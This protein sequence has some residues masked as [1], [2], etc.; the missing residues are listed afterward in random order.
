YPWLL[1]HR[2]GSG[3][4][5]RWN[6]IVTARI[7]GMTAG[8]SAQAQPAATQDT[9]LFDGFLGVA[10]AGRIETTVTGH[11]GTDGVAV[12]PDRCNDQLTHPRTVAHGNRPGGVAAGQDASRA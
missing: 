12:E 6:R 7:P 5:S 3:G 10:G 4:G 1:G 9:M 2:R 8:Q 11:Q